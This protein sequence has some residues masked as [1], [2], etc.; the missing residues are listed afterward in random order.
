MS[1]NRRPFRLDRRAAAWYPT[2]TLNDNHKKYELRY[3]DDAVLRQKS[4]RVAAFGDAEA[5]LVEA[6]A[7]VTAAHRGV[8]LAAPQVGVLKRIILV[9]PSLLPEGADAVLV[10]PEVVD[11]SA[12]EEVEEEGCLSLLSVAAPLARAARVAVRYAD[13]QG[14]GRELEAEGFGARALLHEIDHLDGILYVDRLSRLKRKLVRERFR[15]LHRELG[16]P[17]R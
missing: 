8:G 3:L 4:E 17:N 10:N 5:E 15:K 12:D 2:C 11:S 7:E 9:H 13:V 14:R 16:L 1:G 6:M